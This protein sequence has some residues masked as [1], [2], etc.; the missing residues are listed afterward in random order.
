MLG[1]SAAQRDVLEDTLVYALAESG[2][3]A[4]AAEVL[5][6]RLSRRDSPL[7]ARRRAALATRARR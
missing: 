4:K 7:D 3:T 6:R 2:A 5:D 1:G